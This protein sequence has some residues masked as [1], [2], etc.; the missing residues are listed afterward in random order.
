MFGGIFGQ[1]TGQDIPSNPTV[2][3]ADQN[4]RVCPH[5]DSLAR[6]KIQVATQ[7]VLY[8]MPYIGFASAISAADV[9]RAISASV[10]KVSIPTDAKS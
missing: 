2:E 6:L 10:W 7:W 4:V 8:P 3:K 5:L 1:S 9:D